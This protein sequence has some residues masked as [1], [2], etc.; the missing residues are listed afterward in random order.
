MSL[1]Q[2][3]FGERLKALRAERGLSQQQLAGGGMSPGYLSRLESGARPPTA[4]AVEYLATQLGVSTAEF[5]GL[6]SD[7]LAQALAIASSTEDA[8]RAL[9]I[10]EEALA[11]GAPSEDYALQ[12][13]AMR[14]MSGFQQDIG[15]REAQLRT[16]GQLVDLADSIGRPE[17]QVYSHVSRARCQRA[18][19]Q[20]EHAH[21]SAVQAVATANAH[22]LPPR[23]TAGALMVLISTETAVGNLIEAREHAAELDELAQ[24]LGQVQ[25]TEALW[26]AAHVHL[27]LGDQAGAAQR[28]GTALGL[29]DSR[30]SPL[31]WLRLRLAA[32]SLHLQMSPRNLDVAEKCLVEAHPAVELVGSAVHQQEFTL[33]SA[34]M[35]F[36]RGRLDEAGRRCAELAETTPLLAYQ[37]ELALK[38]LRSQLRVL[39]GERKEGTR[40]LQTLAEEAQARG[41]IDLSKEI[42]RALAETL[43]QL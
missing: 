37:D 28:L 16:L 38:M 29:L 40:E 33:L 14:V 34:Q 9:R 19:G 24:G 2:P 27:R 4:K 30:V 17:L 25:Q 43:A 31:L 21:E 35:A 11:T 5:R 15:D 20:M 3:E 7:S 39:G 12:W 13:Q 36:Y 42:W 1:Q 26:T 18:L 22:S 41:S 32:A 6:R 10:L 8:D 23:D